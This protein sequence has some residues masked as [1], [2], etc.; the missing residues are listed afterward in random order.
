MLLRGQHTRPKTNWE[1][2]P[3]ERARSGACGPKQAENGLQT[4]NRAES[5]ESAPGSDVQQ[6]VAGEFGLVGDE[7]ESGLGLGA[8][9]PLNRIGGALAVA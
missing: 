2:R 9:Q 7:G 4:D 1:K 6:I 8:H 3:E 5:A